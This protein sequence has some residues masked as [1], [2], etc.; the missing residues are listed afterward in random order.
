MFSYEVIT[1]EHGDLLGIIY[2]GIIACIDTILLQ[3][4]TAMLLKRPLNTACVIIYIYYSKA[5][6][7]Y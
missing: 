4:F 7:I 5:M 2:F 6:G 1:E 3:I